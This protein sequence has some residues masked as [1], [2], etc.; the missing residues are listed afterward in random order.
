MHD[1]RRRGGSKEVSS[2]LK[3][4]KVGVYC[5]IRFQNASLI[6]SIY[7]PQTRWNKQPKYATPFKVSVEMPSVAE[8]SA[9]IEGEDEEDPLG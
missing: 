9:P 1:Q 4:P 6:V 7:L 5:C 2:P 3:A 8:A